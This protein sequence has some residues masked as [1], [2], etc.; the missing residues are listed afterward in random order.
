MAERYDHAVACSTVHEQ[1]EAMEPA[2]QQLW[3]EHYKDDKTLTQ[4][5]EETGVP[6]IT[7]R[8][9]KERFEEQ[10]FDALY[11]RGITEMPR[12]R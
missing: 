6:V 2:L 1:I 11:A 10:L 9:R 3:Q 5:A 4:L 12:V 8:R 7:M